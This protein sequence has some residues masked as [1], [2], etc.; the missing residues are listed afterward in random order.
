M[1]NLMEFPGSER[2]SVA[3]ERRLSGL[4]AGVFVVVS[5]LAGLDI[6][7]D[8]GEGTRAGHVVIEAVVLLAGLVGLGIVVR[9]LWRPLDLDVARA[10]RVAKPFSASPPAEPA[11]ADAPAQD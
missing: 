11:R 6:V 2:T 4:L 5:A 10:K 3:R 9:R 8:L 7:T 1:T